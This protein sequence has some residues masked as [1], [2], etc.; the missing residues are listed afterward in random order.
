MEENYQKKKLENKK[1]DTQKISIKSKIQEIYK[2]TIMNAIYDEQYAGMAKEIDKYIH[3][4]CIDFSQILVQKL[5]ENSIQA[6]IISTLNDDGFKHAA[7]VYKIPETNEVFIADPVTDVRVI[8]GMT[9]EEKNTK[10]KDVLLKD[11]WMR[12]PREY[13][14]D[15]GIVTA[16]DE[17]MNICMENIQDQEEIEAIPTI[18][19][20][21][22]K[23]VE[24]ISAVTRLDGLKALM[25]GPTLLAG[26]ALYKKG[27]ATYCSNYTQ[28]GDA[29]VNVYFNSLSEENK[30]IVQRLV[31][32]QPEN[33]CIKRC[34]GFYGEFGKSEEYKNG[35]SV[36]YELVFGIKD[37][38]NMTEAEINLKMYELI[39][40]LHAQEYRQGVFTREEVLANKHNYMNS[41]L[42]GDE[43]FN[44]K[45]CN[46]TEQNTN[47]EIAKNENLIYSS[48][49]NL[50]FDRFENKSRY[51]ESLYRQEHDLR[52]E[53]EIAKEAGVIYWKGMFFEDDKDVELYLQQTQSVEKRLTD[54]VLPVDIV[55]ADI[56][57]R[58][59]YSMIENIKNLFSKIKTKIFKREGR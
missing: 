53:D 51:I 59:S 28:N 11:N 23:K 35:E 57:M 24:P 19:K 9:P 1:I 52:T 29:S 18:N 38:S 43:L 30:K 44:L 22:E 8:S 32:E 46:S 20:T 49:Y 6:G 48:K 40:M 27:I 7:V 17:N 42:L 41:R 55:K 26:Q 14:K 37:T 15:Y 50:F 5:K 31:A 13:V 36:P 39:N 33:Y 12:I 3:G 54:D 34:R 2:E 56:K 21:I 58:I 10:I 25:D 47:N 45:D 4:V 16:Y